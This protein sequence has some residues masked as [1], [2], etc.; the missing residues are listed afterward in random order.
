VASVLLATTVSFIEPSGVIVSCGA[1]RA[2]TTVSFMVPCGVNVTSLVAAGVAAGREA[3][4]KADPVA[5][6]NHPATITVTMAGTARRRA[7]WAVFMVFSWV[8]L[9]AGV[10]CRRSTWLQI[11]VVAGGPKPESDEMQ[12]CRDEMRLGAGNGAA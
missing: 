1:W 9:A 12:V 10:S 2:A 3:S 4:A 5:R 11:R 8:H 6:A 7:G